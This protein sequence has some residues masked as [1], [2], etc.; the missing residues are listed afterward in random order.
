MSSR[1]EVIVNSG[2]GRV[3][4][5]ETLDELKLHFRENGIDA[6]FCLARSGDELK[7]IAKKAS[8]SDAEVIVAAGGDGSVSTVAS[9]LI[10]SNKSLGVLPL[11]TLNNFSKDLQI[12]QEISSAIRVIAENFARDVDSAE[13][14]GRYFINNSSIGLYPRIVRKRNQQQRLGRGKWWAAAWAAW[15]FLWVS[16]FLK[17]RLLIEGREF[18]RKTP[19]VFVG[20]NDYEMDFYNIGRR[21]RLDNGNLSVYLLHRSGRSG[22]FFLV[23][24]TLFGRLRQAADF[25]ERNAAEMQVATKRRLLLVACDGEV[26]AMTTPL[27]YRI[28]PRSLRVIVPKP[29]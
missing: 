29:E 1:V 14:N 28:H 2:S 15:R 26:A 23:L 8:R 21:T 5:P 22:L 12:P 11:G 19:F 10:G 3:S 13:V 18:Y 24:R 6:N 25:E 17:V 7:T 9:Y 16:P 20:N 27:E 4:D